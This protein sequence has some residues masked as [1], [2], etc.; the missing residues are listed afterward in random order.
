MLGVENTTDPE[1]WK[2]NG[3]FITAIS[4]VPSAQISPNYT[5]K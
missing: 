2:G 3:K 5:L 1:I 4:R